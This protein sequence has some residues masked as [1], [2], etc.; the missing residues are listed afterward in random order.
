MYN[1]ITRAMEVELLPCARKFGLRIVIYNP[2]AYVLRPNSS[3]M[4]PTDL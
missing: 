3:V 4:T 2:L 1:A